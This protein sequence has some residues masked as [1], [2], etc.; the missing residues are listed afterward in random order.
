[1]PGLQE[2]IKH[3]VVLMLENRSFDC[4]LGALYP[5]RTDFNGLIGNESNSHTGG[6][7]TP[8]GVWNDDTI[9]PG[10]MTA[11]TPDPGELFDDM[12]TQ[13]FGFGAAASNE[14]PAMSGFVDN[15][16][17]QTLEPPYPPK[18]V[19]HYY[20]PK[21]VPVISTLA[22][23]YA[24]CDQWHASAPNQTWPNRFFAHCATAGGYVNNSPPH[25]PY[26]MPTIFD[27]ITRSGM[28]NGWK[29]YFHDM[30][31]TLTLTHLWLQR[32]RFRLFDEFID[33]ATKGNLP[34]YSFIEPRYFADLGLGMPNDQHPPHDVVFA[35]QLIAT[36][37][38][39]LRAS[40]LWESSLLVITHDEHG[41]C[42]DHA[43]PPLAVSPGDHHPNDA[44]AFDR[45]GVRV[46]AV[47]VSPYIQAGTILRSASGG[48]PHRG[49]PYPYDHTSIIATLRKCFNLGGPMTARD[50]A[51]P[52]LDPVLN[53][54]APVNNQLG[55]ITVSAYQPSQQDL[56]DAIGR[57]LTHMQQ[58]LH[59]LSAVLPPPGVDMESYIAKL[60]SGIAPIAPLVQTSS[61]ALSFISQQL[62]KIL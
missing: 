6:L 47:I 29:I 10:T 40:P 51:A 53:L 61:A 59:E 35:E 44:F 19:M 49:P 13:L 39:T 62:G 56:Q 14:P 55:T 42:F 57:P 7:E 48:L 52:D 45:Y 37:Y 12:T 15:Y 21:Q 24:V 38:N 16:T 17:R 34:G 36:V 54:D 32:D 33:D 28:P 50:A 3:V 58:A 11:P 23:H 18:A 26:M 30:P 43:P 46:P 31:Q 4:I 25:F 2:K 1:M 9:V 60:A 8:I 20:T 41:G 27:R 5:G 22:Q